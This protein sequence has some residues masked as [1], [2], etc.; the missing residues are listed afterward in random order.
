MPGI[1][2]KGD[3]RMSKR[4][5]ILLSTV[6]ILIIGSG[7]ATAQL[8][9]YGN[10]PDFT[11]NDIDGNEH[12]LYEYL[13]SGKVVLIDFF[14]VW[15]GICW[16]NSPVLEDIY[17]EYGPE[18]VGSIELLSLEADNS[19]TDQEVIDF[20]ERFETSNPHF[21]ETANVGAL[22]NLTGFPYYYVV[23][24][25]R[26]YKVFA[27]TTMNLEEELSIAIE[28]S[29]GLREVENDI[30]I[31]NFTE[32]TGTYCKKLI[33]PKIEFQ[34]Y[35]NNDVNSFII[36]LEIDGALFYSYE[37]SSTL[38]PYEY[39]ELTLPELG[40]LEHGWHEFDVTVGSVNS[41]D[42]GEDNDRTNTGFFLFLEESEEIVIQVTTDTYP[43][44]T[45]WQ[46]SE[47]GKVAAERV[48]FNKAKTLFSDTLC[49]EVDH[50]YSL[51]LFDHFGDGLS[52]G[53]LRVLYKGEII[54]EID[55]NS[56][57][58]GSEQIQFCLSSSTGIDIELLGFDPEIYPNPAREE[59]N[60][61]FP[62]II[63][64]PVSIYLVNIY[65]QIV[66]EEHHVDA[67][68]KKTIELSAF[69]DGI[70]FL[71]VVLAEG[72][73]TKKIFIQK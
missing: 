42:D 10:A 11:L 37:H 32:P 21:N 70:I 19:T 62:D 40:N 14:A 68:S 36:N 46:V 63:Q 4:I 2:F 60:I 8:D 58:S 25:D 29:P 9:G 16:S 27:G 61:S 13:D 67:L 48:P 57:N 65:G 69:S 24:P 28:A 66:F 51:D 59:I 1:C 31:I 33:I 45:Y 18:G 56:F 44:E 22:Y 3:W 6:L 54:G 49:L 47:D 5:I 52:E 39:I 7:S 55:A 30:R 64:G 71:R 17:L 23:A 34:N 50:C 12:H 73:I 43:K 26:S 53:G 38:I 35:G 15:C 41:L 72:S 20:I